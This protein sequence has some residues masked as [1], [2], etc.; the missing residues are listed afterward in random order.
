LLLVMIDYLQMID[1]V[2]WVHFVWLWWVA[3]VWICS[4]GRPVA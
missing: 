4:S 3:C 1:H 2:W